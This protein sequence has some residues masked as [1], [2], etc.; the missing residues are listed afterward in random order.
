MRVLV[1]HDPYRPIESGSVGGEDNLANLE[2]EVLA[3]L[4]HEVIDGRFHDEGIQRKVNQ[5]R[6]Q[7]FGSHPGVLDLITNSKP[8]VIHTHNLN[9]RSGYSWMNSC[10]V[11][12]VSSIHNYRL[13]CP[14]S[15]A[16]R[17]GQIC[18]DCVSK[19]ALSALK[20]KCDGGRGAINA[21]RHLLFQREY[22]Q[23][24]APSLF[25]MSS[26]LMIGVFKTLIADEKMSVLRNP[27]FSIKSSLNLKR[28]GW[29]FAGRFV[30][31]KGILELIKMWPDSESLDI[32][33]DGPLHSAIVRKIQNKSNIRLI[34]TY[35]PGEN[36][37]LSKYEGMIFNSTWYEGSPL[38]IVDSFGAGTPVICTDVSAAREQ[39][40]IS[41]AGVV[42]EGHVSEKGLLDA[43]RE[44]R[45]HFESYQAN[46]LISVKHE[47]SVDNWGL[48]LESHLGS[49]AR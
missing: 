7:S 48:K 16:W 49:V 34:G 38:V 35:P 37:I 22:P 3:N 45:A 11:P 30:A 12:I 32:A 21:S 9:Q 31:E 18:V 28:N 2:I 43:I 10:A 6:A 39:V 46:A 14:S 25:L 36:S 4:G 29:I 27:S 47:F 19:N 1:L 42:I 40:Q 24:E 5:I 13:F 20:H 26:D 23:L 8:D 15:I 41:K 33:G 44:I 17:D